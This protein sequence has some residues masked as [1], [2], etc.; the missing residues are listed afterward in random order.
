[1]NWKQIF[2]NLLVIGG[3]YSVGYFSSYFFSRRYAINKK[4]KEVKDDS[5][6]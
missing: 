5:E 2:I 4:Q 3:V 1:M 6:K